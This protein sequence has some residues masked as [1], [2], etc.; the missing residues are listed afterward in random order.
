[1]LVYTEQLD[2]KSQALRREAELKALP[3]N[4]K[5]ALCAPF[6]QAVQAL[7]AA[8]RQDALSLLESGARLLE[9]D[10]KTVRIQGKDG[11]EQVF[12]SEKQTSP[13]RMIPAGRF[14]ESLFFPGGV[15]VHQGDAQPFNALIVHFF[16]P[17]HAGV[18]R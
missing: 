2:D 9:C 10:G 17:A 3:R 1:M 8:G 13:G 16:P 14:Y 5:L 4:R 15:L 12:F 18:S 11:A 7:T 6:R